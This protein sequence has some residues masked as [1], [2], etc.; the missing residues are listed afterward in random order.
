MTNK[1][2]AMLMLTGMIT[3]GGVTFQ[4]PYV[5][6]VSAEAA[7]VDVR[8][9]NWQHKFNIDE[10]FISDLKKMEQRCKQVVLAGGG[11]VDISDLNPDV[12]IYAF[13]YVNPRAMLGDWFPYLD[14]NMGINFRSYG[15]YIDVSLRDN[16]LS[17]LAKQY[18]L[19]DNALAWFDSGIK[20]NMTDE[21][22]V[23]YIYNFMEAYK[24]KNTGNSGE[25]LLQDGEIEYSAGFEY[26]TAGFFTRFGPLC[27]G[28]VNTALYLSARIGLETYYAEDRHREP[29]HAWNLVRVDGELYNCDFFH[30]HFLQSDQSFRNLSDKNSDP[31]LGWNRDD[32]HW[33]DTQNKNGYYCTSTKYDDEYAGKADLVSSRM[34]GLVQKYRKQFSSSLN[35]ERKLTLSETSVSIE[36]G[37]DHYLASVSLDDSI[38]INES[39]TWKSSNPSVV[40]VDS[41]G[42]IKGV[43]A[44]TAD[45]IV[46]ASNGLSAACKITVTPAKP[47]PPDGTPSIINCDNF[48]VLWTSSQTAMEDEHPIKY[49]S[50]FGSI[51]PLPTPPSRGK[52]YEFLGWY[53]AETGGTRVT[54]S[55]KTPKEAL[56]QVNSLK[57]NLYAHWKK[58][59]D[60]NAI[61]YTIKFNGNGATS[62]SAKSMKMVYGKAKELPEHSLNRKGYRFMGWSLT[63]NG[64]VKYGDMDMVKNLCKKNGGTVTLYAVWKKR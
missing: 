53:T 1:A 42:K 40:T 10:N 36:A 49:N 24:E 17:K 29:G 51:F 50:T 2:F 25:F 19:I 12:G 55:T 6:C 5:P 43:S 62:G 37:S 21:E 52:G 57:I 11:K 33:S 39:V 13:N 22:K 44:G 26:T 7:V 32:L 4:M 14:S 34:F 61:R 31:S 38:S 59:E 60:A 47:A 9:D 16:N 20:P 23:F 48:V 18:A 3:I 45:I 27:S 35:P 41:N 28:Y 8:T 64:K 56:D 58:V 46:T 30:P 15:D 63:K 54:D